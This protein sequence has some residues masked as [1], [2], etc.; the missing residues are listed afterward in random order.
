MVGQRRWG[1][2][3]R[4]WCHRMQYLFDLQIASPLGE[5]FVFTPEHLA[6]YNE[7]SEFAR[8]VDAGVDGWTAE[9]VNFIRHLGL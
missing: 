6:A 5:K 7:P 3:V 9:R 2:L 4:A 1:V 8:L